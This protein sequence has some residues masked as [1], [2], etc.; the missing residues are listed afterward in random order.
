MYKKHQVI[1]LPTEKESKL[2]LLKDD[3]IDHLQLYLTV[4]RVPHSNGFSQQHLYILSSEPIKEGDYITDDYMNVC[5]HVD[6]SGMGLGHSLNFKKVIATTDSTLGLPLISEEFIKTFIKAY[7]EQKPI[8]SVMVEWSSNSDGWYDKDKEIWCSNP[9]DLQ[10]INNFI[11][12][13]YQKD[14]F[15]RE[16]VEGLITKAL[17]DCQSWDQHVMNACGIDEYALPHFEKMVNEWI[18]D[19]L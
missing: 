1:M 3:N 11:N 6:L 13:K 19:N 9:V 18:E 17:T 16:E 2:V 14:T 12:I 15:S 5:K 7:N 4:R 10:V 8:T